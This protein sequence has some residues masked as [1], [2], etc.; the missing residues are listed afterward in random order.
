MEKEEVKK[1]EIIRN[2]NAQTHQLESIDYLSQKA[3]SI[4]KDGPRIYQYIQQ[5]GNATVRFNPK[6]EIIEIDYE[7][8]IRMKLN[9]NI[10]TMW[11][12]NPE[13]IF[14]GTFYSTLKK[15]PNKK[16]LKQFLNSFYAKA[17]EMKEL[18]EKQGPHML[19]QDVEIQRMLAELDQIRKEKS[20]TETEIGILEAKLLELQAEAILNREISDIQDKLR[21]QK[22]LADKRQ[23][24]ELKQKRL[25]V[26][27][28]PFL[29]KRILKKYS[30]EK[31]NL[32]QQYQEII[33][34]K[35]KAALPEIYQERDQRVHW[36]QELEQQKQKK[37][38]LEQK[39][40]ELK[41]KLYFDP[42]L[43]TTIAE[44]K[45]ATLERKRA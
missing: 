45:G 27:F 33:A 1:A 24:S 8:G 23:T 7:N 22:K 35:Q 13:D 19:L 16:E 21:R 44:E 5:I 12:T 43:G 39:E 20:K 32:D 36:Q 11:D 14:L 40:E 3:R 34:Q 30:E 9:Q 15:V 10:I 25:L 37:W 38:N 29:H 26:F 17:K 18:V 6:G 31:A 28:F 2:Y 42:S 41:S 4:Y